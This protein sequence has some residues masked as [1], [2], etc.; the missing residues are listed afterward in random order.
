MSVLLIRLSGPMQS[1]GLSSRFTERDTAREPTKSGVIGLLCAAL[2]KP[3]EEKPGDGHP[4]LAELAAL[5]MGVRVD[6][7]GAV[8]R[9][10]HTAGGGKWPGRKDY[11]VAK[12]GGAKGDTVI[13]N[14]YY[15][16][17]AVFLVG[18]EGDTDLLRRLEKA[19]RSPV[20]PL[21]LGRKSFP[22]GE[23][24]LLPCGFRET[25]SLE[26]ALHAFPWLRRP[27]PNEQ[28]PDYLRLVIECGFCEAGETRQDVP[29]SFE[30]HR[31]ALGDAF[32]VRHVREDRLDPNPLP[33]SVEVPPCT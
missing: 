2:G 24:L 5:R 10:F 16:T 8:R 3:R 9:D 17:D 23:P 25:G 21:F 22:P 13:S 27:R 30:S 7:E 11:G 6:H 31:R 15:L 19:L 28:A 20:W 18:L 12:A 1:W 14:R 4:L 26:E 29:L 33:E 32:G